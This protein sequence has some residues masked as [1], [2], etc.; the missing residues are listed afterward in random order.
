MVGKSLGE[1][2]ERERILPGEVDISSERR[3]RKAATEG[4]E[5]WS[6]EVARREKSW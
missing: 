3:R 2:G 1:E 6:M 4:R 5:I